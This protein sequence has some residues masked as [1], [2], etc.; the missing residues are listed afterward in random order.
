MES[1]G[2]HT[3][4]HARRGGSKSDNSDTDITKGTWFFAACQP[5]GLEVTASTSDVHTSYGNN[6]EKTA[7]EN[8][9]I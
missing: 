7:E 1:A 2:I 8:D 9:V 4:Y 3:N 5:S 6:R